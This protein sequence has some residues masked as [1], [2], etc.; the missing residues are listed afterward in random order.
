MHYHGNKMVYIRLSNLSSEDGDFECFWSEWSAGVMVSSESDQMLLGS[1]IGSDHSLI[2]VWTMVWFWVW[3]MV[4]R[5]SD[6]NSFGLESLIRTLWVWKVW[7]EIFSVWKVWSETISVW[8][9]W[10]DIILVWKV[11]SEA[12]LGLDLNLGYLHSFFHSLYTFWK[13]CNLGWTDKKLHSHNYHYNQI[14][15][16][17]SSIIWQNG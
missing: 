11:W 9:V 15:T 1:E 12:N 2:K 3:T 6:R 5:W 4:W 13:E 16:S 7:S 17:S 8:K 10:S 14:E